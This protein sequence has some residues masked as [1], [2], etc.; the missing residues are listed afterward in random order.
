MA[1]PYIAL[2]SGQLT[3]FGAS[4]SAPRCCLAGM[5]CGQTHLGLHCKAPCACCA[6]APMPQWELATCTRR[7][8]LLHGYRGRVELHVG[9]ARA[10]T[11]PEAPVVLLV[12]SRF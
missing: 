4:G 12:V 10:L 3:D 1:A 11:L 9:A 2:D 7:T 8:R 5:G 6:T